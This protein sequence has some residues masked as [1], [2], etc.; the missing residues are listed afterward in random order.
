MIVPEMNCQ[1]T[2]ATTAKT[3]YGKPSVGSGTSFPKTTARTP[4]KTSGCSTAQLIPKK[5]CL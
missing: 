5:L 3:A 4:A 2:I 1:G